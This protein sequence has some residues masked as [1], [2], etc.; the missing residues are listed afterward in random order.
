MRHLNNGTDHRH[1]K[2]CCDQSSPARRTTIS[3]HIRFSQFYKHISM[4][5]RVLL[6]WQEYKTSRFVTPHQQY[7]TCG[8]ILVLETNCRNNIEDN[9]R[10][11]IFIPWLPVG[12]HCMTTMPKR[13]RL[14]S[15]LFSNKDYG[16]QKPKTLDKLLWQ[17][18]VGSKLDRHEIDIFITNWWY[19]YLRRTAV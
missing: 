15:K 13:F 7:S 3:F 10:E 19:T 2:S 8:V 17:M 5:L 6:R 9:N 18:N 12:S 4:Y 14:M 16:T 1:S 11:F